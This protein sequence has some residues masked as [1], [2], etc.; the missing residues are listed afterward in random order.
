MLIDQ[1]VFRSLISI[2]CIPRVSF[3][4]EL[5]KFIFIYYLINICINIIYM[6]LLTDRTNQHCSVIFTFLC[7]QVLSVSSEFEK[8]VWVGKLFFEKYFV[9]TVTTLSMFT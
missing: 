7:R 5:I 6:M 9:K 4:F 1:L 2:D 3:A 8:K